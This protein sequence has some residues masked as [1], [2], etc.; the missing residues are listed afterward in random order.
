M[1]KRLRPALRNPAALATRVLRI[2]VGSIQRE[3][4]RSAAGLVHARLV[5][6]RFLQRFGSALNE[7]WHCHCW[8]SDG[9]FVAADGQRLA[10]VSASVDADGAAWVKAWVRRPVL[11][12]DRR[13]GVLDSEAAANMA[14]SDLVGGFSVDAS[15]VVATW[16]QQSACNS[17]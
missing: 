4:H 9:V 6:V 15:V 8:L 17:A 5:V 3:L 16:Q 14:D 2:F 1:P 11:A 7:H 12:A 10:F 13:H